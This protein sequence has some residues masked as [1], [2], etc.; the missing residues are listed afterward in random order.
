MT[1][2]PSGPARAPSTGPPHIEHE[3]L[4]PHAGAIPASPFHHLFIFRLYRV[5]SNQPLEPAMATDWSITH[6]PTPRYLSTHFVTSLL[7]PATFSVLKLGLDGS[8][9]AGGNGQL[10][11]RRSLCGARVGD[12]GIC[13]HVRPVERFIPARNAETGRKTVSQLASPRRRRASIQGRLTQHSVKG[14]MGQASE[15]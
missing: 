6:S 8:P 12:R 4:S 10:C 9:D 14:I 3:K 2:P 13:T 5:R 1:R 15:L 11:G 7:S